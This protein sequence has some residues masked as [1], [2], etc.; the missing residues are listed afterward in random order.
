MFVV[1]GGKDTTGV[2]AWIQW[3]L[4]FVFIILKKNPS[5]T[6]DE[7]ND[8]VFKKINFSCKY[9]KWLDTEEWGKTIDFILWDWEYIELQGVLHFMMHFS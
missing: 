9:G 3:K 4:A 7:A 5:L 1:A 2:V 6:I 8:L